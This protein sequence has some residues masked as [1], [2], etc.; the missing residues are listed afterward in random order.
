VFEPPTGC[1]FAARCTRT[2]EDCTAPDF[3]VLG[4]PSGG[5]EHTCRHPAGA[6]S[7]TRER[8]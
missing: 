1:R 8:E 6:V 4:V 2:A 3:T 7:A 5:H